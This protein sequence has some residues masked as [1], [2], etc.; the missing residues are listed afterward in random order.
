[1]RFAMHVRRVT[2]FFALLALAAWVRA[3]EAPKKEEPKPAKEEPKTELPEDAVAKVDNMVITRADVATVRKQI[4]MDPRIAMPNTEQLVDRLIERALLQRYFD[5]ESLRAS[6]ADIQ[7]AIQ[8]IDAKLREQGGTYQRL[9]A[10]L[11]IT[12]EEHAVQLGFQLSQA[13]LIDR[14]QK[15]ITDEE[16]KAEFEAHQEWYDGSRIHLAQI[17][18]E[19]ADLGNDPEKLKKA[20]EKIEKVHADLVAGKDFARLAQDFSDRPSGRQGGDEGWVTR[21]GLPQQ[22]LPEED[23]PLIAAAWAMKVGEFSKPIQGPRGWHILKVLDREPA[24]LTFFGAKPNVI[25]EL[26]RRRVKALLD[27]LK[28]KATIEKRF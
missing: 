3:G 2:L 13:R 28:S 26:T 10:R 17:F 14:I 21:K 23:E 15:D 27:Q 7:R 18:I 20:K 25:Q 22:P 1:M 5:K 11:G 12:A 19:T 4:A 6:G 9:I 24:R 16:V 8:Q